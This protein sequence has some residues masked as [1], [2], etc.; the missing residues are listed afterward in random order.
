MRASAVHPAAGFTMGIFV[1][2]AYKELDNRRGSFI[3]MGI[4]I[5]VVIA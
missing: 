5:I 2:Q 3:I 1:I 4:G